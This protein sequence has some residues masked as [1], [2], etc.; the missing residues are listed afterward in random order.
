MTTSLYI[1]AS[2]YMQIL[3]VAQARS[4]SSCLTKAIKCSANALH[5]M[6]RF[7][8]AKRTYSEAIACDPLNE[9]ILVEYGYLLYDL[10]LY[11]ETVHQV[12][13]NPFLH[14]N[15]KLRFLLAKSYFQL[16]NY[17]HAI[18]WL[19][20][21]QSTNSKPIPSSSSSSPSKTTSTSSTLFNIPT[22]PSSNMDNLSLEI[23]SYTYE[24]YMNLHDYKKALATARAVTLSNPGS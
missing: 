19:E 9:E 16:Q 11:N 4:T 20:L 22:V 14:S 24:S 7:Q 8:T 3:P 23:L 15:I 17:H 21:I 10:E 18:Y 1:S 5:S 6:R 12:I 2:T 13:Q